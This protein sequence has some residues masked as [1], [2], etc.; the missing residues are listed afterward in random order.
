[1]ETAGE[2]TSLVLANCQRAAELI[3]GFKQVAV[4]Q[5]SAER[6]RFPLAN[7]IREVLRSLSPKLRQACVEVTIDC[8][9]EVEVDSFPGA[10]SQVLTNLVMNSIIHG[11]EERPGGH[12]SIRVAQPSPEQVE[13]CYS[14]DGRGIAPDIRPRIFDPFFTTKRG[15]G[16]N[17][18]GLHVVFNVVTGTL[19]GQIAVESELGQGSTFTVTFPRIAPRD[20]G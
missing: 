11:F 5:T 20:E 17:G 1:M 12:I 18:L 19:K 13:L 4:D 9:V 14:D 8:T 6:R 15:S 7:Y 2:A 10:L 16:G 3:N